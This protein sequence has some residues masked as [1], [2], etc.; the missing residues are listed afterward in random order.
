MPHKPQSNIRLE[1]QDCIFWIA[2]LV[3]VLRSFCRV[4]DG[5]ETKKGGCIKTEAAF[6]EPFLIPEHHLKHPTNFIQLKINGPVVGVSLIDNFKYSGI[7]FC[8]FA[9]AGK[10]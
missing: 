1:K 8:G 10:A 4:L 2:N 9:M 5:F 6:L 3:K 7:N